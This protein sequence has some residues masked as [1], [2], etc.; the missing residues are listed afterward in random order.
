[1]QSKSRSQADDARQAAGLSRKRQKG[2]EPDAEPTYRR[3]STA[4]WNE[5]ET[6]VQTRRETEIDRSR[7]DHELPRGDETRGWR[8]HWRHGIFG[9]L[10]HWAAGSLG[11][12]IFMLAA[13]ARDFDVVDEVGEVLGF[14]PRVEVR[15]AETCIYIVG[16]LRSYLSV[17]KWAKTE[18]QRHDV[19]VVLGACAARREEGDTDPDG[20]IE[21]VAL[22]TLVFFAE[23]FR[24]PHTTGTIYTV[25]DHTLATRTFPI[26]SMVSF[27]A[28][29]A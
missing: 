27:L 14:L 7:H 10:R 16:R 17:A 24:Q 28:T 29:T 13:C 23:G 5:L 6:K 3:W 25:F 20:M 21:R 11:A 26:L 8:H 4:K 9:A 1:M 2:S 15:H 22:L 12:I 19:H 18:E